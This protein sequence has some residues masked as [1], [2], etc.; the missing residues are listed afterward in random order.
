[1]KRLDRSEIRHNIAARVDHDKEKLA[2]EAADRARATAEAEAR[3]KRAMSRTTDSTRAYLARADLAEF[4]DWYNTE[5][6][7][8]SLDDQTPDETYW[9]RLPEMKAA[10]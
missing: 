7:H 5:R 3:Q 4:I 9:A 6:P 1:M 2:K 10:A 8:S